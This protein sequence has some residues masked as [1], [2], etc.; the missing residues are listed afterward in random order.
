MRRWL[1]LLGWAAIWGIIVAVSA[2]GVWVAISR[3]GNHVTSQTA[4]TLPGT[5]TI[6]PAAQP[7]PR[8]TPSATPRPIPQATPLP[9]PRPSSRP[10]PSDPR[11]DNPGP[12]A[13]RASWSGS[14]GRVTAT[15]R[16][17]QIRLDAAVP[18]N[19]FSVEIGNRGPETLE[20]EFHQTRG[21]NESKVRGVC[22]A[23]G[24]VFTVEQE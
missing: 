11:T 6:T 5:H 1:P 12:V 23:G 19:G 13:T 17:Q 18:A 15:C 14:A 10:T 2:T 24:P 22:R 8:A 16:G 9:T 3:A 7:T 21:E 20:I 4:P